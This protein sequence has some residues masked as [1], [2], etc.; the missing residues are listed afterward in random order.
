MR[1]T[2]TVKLDVRP[3]GSFPSDDE[4]IAAIR[5]YGWEPRTGP[6]WEYFCSIGA[7]C[8]IG[9]KAEQE[10]ERRQWYREQAETVFAEMPEVIVTDPEREAV[11]Y[12]GIM[13]EDNTEFI[14]T[15]RVMGEIKF[16]LLHKEL[17]KLQS[18]ADRA[19][20]NV[21]EEEIFCGVIGSQVTVYERG[22]NIVLLSGYV[23]SNRWREAYKRDSRDIALTIVPLTLF[24][25]MFPL[26]YKFGGPLRPDIR[27]LSDRF[28]TA[29]F[30]TA[31]VSALSF[32]SVFFRLG[33]ESRIVWN[34]GH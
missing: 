8:A 34:Y 18:A 30:T 29:M 9:D 7:A 21:L 5:G 23:V 26:D 27:A 1:A 32:L 25:V 22:R 19:V 31:I 17:L 28:T 14:V 16:R 15:R 24:L 6:N 20:R 33:R 3:D 12:F 4:V 13:A 2:F 10:K 11:I